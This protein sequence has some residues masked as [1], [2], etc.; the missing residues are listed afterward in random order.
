M[1]T[2]RAASGISSP[3]ER[4]RIARAVP[5]LVGGAHQP[6]RPAC[7][8]GAARRIRSPISVCVR[9]YPHSASSSGRACQDR[10]RDGHLADVVQLRRL[11]VSLDVRRDQAEPLRERDGPARPPPSRGGRDRGRAREGRRPAP[12]R[13]GAPGSAGRPSRRTCADR[14]AGADRRTLWRHGSAPSR[15]RGDVE[16]VAVLGQRAGRGVHQRLER[17]GSRTS[18]QNS[19]PPSG[20]PSRP[21]RGQRACRRAARAARRR[22]VPERVVVQLEPVEIE[23]RRPRPSPVLARLAQIGEQGAAVAEA[24]ELVGERLAPRPREHP[25]VLGDGPCHPHDDGEEGRHREQRGERT[26]RM[27]GREPEHADGHDGEDRGRASRD[28]TP[29]PARWHRAPRP[30][31][32]SRRARRSSRLEHGARR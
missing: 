17:A 2:I 28:R 29:D 18:T 8:A 26:A 13:S 15:R 3:R 5:A 24:G 22:R 25:L 11:A 20:T 31:R 30:P 19:S 14:P 21:S 9:M 6:A 10:V 4:V 23:E 16:P 1:P 12:R 7:S 32:R 27:E